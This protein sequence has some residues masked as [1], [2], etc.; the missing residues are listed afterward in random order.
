MNVTMFWDEGTPN[1][2]EVIVVPASLTPT[3][4][5]ALAEMHNVHVMKLE[6]RDMFTVNLS[7]D[8]G[9]YYYGSVPPLT[10][11]NNGGW[12]DMGTIP[13]I[14]TPSPYDRNFFTSH[15]DHMT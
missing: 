8:E 4:L 10:T 1:S 7:L 14:I 5:V 12:F 13:S 15:T 11:P 6:S 3:V 2:V 9:L